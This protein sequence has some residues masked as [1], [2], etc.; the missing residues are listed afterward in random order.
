VQDD[1]RTGARRSLSVYGHVVYHGP[2]RRSAHR[3]AEG[4]QLP[5]RRRG[6]ENNNS[7]HGSRGAAGTVAR[8][9][10]RGIR[11]TRSGA[12]GVAAAPG[13]GHRRRGGI[14]APRPPSR[15]HAGAQHPFRRMGAGRGGIVPAR[16]AA[17]VS[18]RLAGFNRVPVLWRSWAS[19]W[20]T[21]DWPVVEVQLSIDGGPGAQSFASCADNE[22]AAGGSDA[23]RA[24]IHP[25]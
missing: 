25:V 11:A 19:W 1:S 6:M 3:P 22:A 15:G 14:G 12:S 24:P 9:R 13:G 2:I 5:I 8:G 17:S 20:P 18:R 21:S 7:E 10:Y 16:I 23:R 4:V